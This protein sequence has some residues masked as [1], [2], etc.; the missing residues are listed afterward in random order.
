M[1]IYSNDS[2]TKTLQCTTYKDML[3]RN[4]LKR[5]ANLVS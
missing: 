2:Y 1:G 3:N 4:Q 5:S